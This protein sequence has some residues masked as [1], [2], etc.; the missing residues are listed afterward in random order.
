MIFIVNR[1]RY[2][3]L[4]VGGSVVLH[5][6]FV[7][8]PSQGLLRP[9]PRVCM[10][11]SG[12]LIGFAHSLRFLFILACPLVFAYNMVKIRVPKRPPV[13]QS[14]ACTIHSLHICHLSDTSDTPKNHPK[15][16]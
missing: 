3:L 15:N 4:I 9:Q 2:H 1:Y 13:L 14:F 10:I 12:L 7:F 11:E 16:V 6:V 5:A 8:S